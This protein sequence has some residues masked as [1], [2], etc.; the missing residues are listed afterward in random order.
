MPFCAV[1][2]DLACATDSF[3]DSLA[4]EIRSLTLAPEIRSLTDL[5][6]NSCFVH[7]FYL[8]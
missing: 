1:Q 3:G 5:I 4:P 7:E 8:K 2:S 6:F